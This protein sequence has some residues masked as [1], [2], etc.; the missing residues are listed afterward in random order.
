MGFILRSLYSIVKVTDI[1]L[2]GQEESVEGY[3]FTKTEARKRYSR[4]FLYIYDILCAPVSIWKK[5]KHYVKTHHDTATFGSSNLYTSCCLDH[6]CVESCKMLSKF[7]RIV[8]Q[9]L[10]VD[11][12]QGWN[13]PTARSNH[14]AIQNAEE[15]VA[16]LVQIV[17][18]NLS[19]ATAVI[20][21]T[22]LFPIDS[23]YCLIP[24]NGKCGCQKT[25]GWYYFSIRK[26]ILH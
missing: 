12:H 9:K 10:S 24:E 3:E 5:C 7:N 1:V 18:K 2:N 13:D 21:P 20:G 15:Y 22:S 25:L 6:S 4:K 23:I 17:I 14:W 8:R 16:K 26:V 11:Y 19:K